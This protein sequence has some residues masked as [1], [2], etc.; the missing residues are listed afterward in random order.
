M[1]NDALPKVGMPEVDIIVSEVVQ[2]RKSW[3]RSKG[4]RVWPP[5]LEAALIEGRYISLISYHFD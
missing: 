1:S 5:E 4:E 2:G 3:K